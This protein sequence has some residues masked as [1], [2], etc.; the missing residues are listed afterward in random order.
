GAP[1]ASPA[2]FGRPTASELLDA[3]REYLTG[4]VLPG[5]SGQ[6]AFHARVAANALAIVAR[7]LELGAFPADVDLAGAV[8]ARLAVA[9]P[10][11]FETTPAR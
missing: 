11:Y 2:R 3:V 10:K 6:L 1:A 5:T 4:S 7:E 8:A 9:N